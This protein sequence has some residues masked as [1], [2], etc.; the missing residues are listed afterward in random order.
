MRGQWQVSWFEGDERP[1]DTQIAEVIFQLAEFCC[2]LLFEIYSL[3]DPVVIVRRRL[4]KGMTAPAGCLSHHSDDEDFISP[5]SYKVHLT[6]SLAIH[7]QDSDTRGAMDSS[8]KLPT[9]VFHMFEFTKR[10]S[11]GTGTS[12]IRG[13]DGTSRGRVVVGALA[14]Q[15]RTPG[16]GMSGMV[17]VDSMEGGKDSEPKAKRSKT[18]AVLVSPDSEPELGFFQRTDVIP[19]SDDEGNDEVLCQ[20]LSHVDL[21][22][23]ERAVG[24]PKDGA[25]QE[26]D[27]AED[28]PDEGW[29]HISRPNKR[30]RELPCEDSETSPHVRLGSLN[31]P[32]S[33]NL[34]VQLLKPPQEP[35]TAPHRRL[36]YMIKGERC[37]LGADGKPVLEGKRDH[38]EIKDQPSTSR[39]QVELVDLE[40]SIEDLEDNLE[41]EVEEV[42]DQVQHDGVAVD[43]DPPPPQTNNPFKIA[44]RRKLWEPAPLVEEELPPDDEDE[45]LARCEELS[46]K[47]RDSLDQHMKGSQTWTGQESDG[48]LVQRDQLVAACGPRARSLKPYQ[49]AGINFLMLLYRRGIGGAI[50]ADEM[51]LG[52]TAQA[53]TF[54]AALRAV[55]NNPGP[56]LVVAPASLLENWEREL[57]TWAPQL[58]VC[59]FY[60]P[61]R[62]EV[63]EK[64]QRWR[65][66]MERALQE[67][68]VA[69]PPQGYVQKTTTVLGGGD[70]D[71]DDDDV[72][73]DDEEDG[74][75]EDGVGG[76]REGSLD[77]DEEETVAEVHDGGELD[78]NSVDQGLPFDV[79]LTGYTMFE[80]TSDDYA[81]NRHFLCKWQ[82]SHAV[83]DEAHALKNITSTRSQKLLKV[84]KNCRCRIM[85]TGTP[86][87]NDLRE[88]QNLLVFLVPQIFQ[89]DAAKGMDQVNDPA[90]QEKMV[91]RM[92]KLLAPFVLRRLKSEVADQLVTKSHRLEKVEMTSSQAELYH[93]TVNNMKAELM[94]ASSKGKRG[95]KS[96]VD[97][98]VSS[99][100][101]SRMLQKLGAKRI[102]NI[103]TELRKIAQHPLL[104]RSLYTE[105]QMEDIIERCVKYRLFGGTCTL[106]RVRQELEGYSDF[107]L[108]SL[109]T[110]HPQ[111]MSQ[112]LLPPD[113]VMASGKFHYLANLLP[114]LKGQG[115][116]VLIFSQWTSVLD[117]MEWFL[118]QQGFSF[119]RLDGSTAVEDRLS[120]VDRFN[121]PDNGIFAFLLSTRA[122]GQGL[123]LTGADT[124]I[125]HDVDFNPQIDRQAEDRCH[126]LGQTRPVVVY[127]LVAI[128][129][130]DEKILEIADHKLR[131]DAAVLDD[132]TVNKAA[133]GT[134]GGEG[135]KAGKTAAKGETKHYGEILACLFS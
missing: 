66:K 119:L 115:S 82:W 135:D 132:L 123:N 26:A 111:V 21:E 25:P 125:L 47:L 103:F 37:R 40:H 41:D 15:S 48:K 31:R 68:R 89:G 58:R 10:D 30:T 51:G 42:P 13:S 46:R 116:R 93:Q 74:D 53:A 75:L 118:D 27:D 49:L 88:L 126:R 19:A 56:H 112:Y 133:G 39:Q 77:D 16:G 84:V 29:T 11:H 80:K 101:S 7:P 117:I 90:E 94:A 95:K 122:G 64:L 52:K 17:R 120:L 102:N 86:L 2:C 97:G 44:G 83:L 100:V 96:E 32:T 134:G 70:D 38:Q 109:M 45:V 91:E 50:L 128:G 43:N 28:S 124:V 54:L 131:L 72:E 106:S 9:N 110:H 55:E 69:S 36:R 1:S 78:F 104:T 85:L 8:R 99:G 105:E 59:P 24:Q 114:Q 65:G 34:Q 57:K 20:D 79:M 3:I 12:S 18:C 67:G 33:T 22:V 129:T 127:R 60:G 5:H 61:H 130:V 107:K 98:A 23:G 63:K 92:K 14:E 81:R 121:D 6:K 71:D 87:Q 4:G 62:E 113:A 73:D 35:Q 76:S 108:H